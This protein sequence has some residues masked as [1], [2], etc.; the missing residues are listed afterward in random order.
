MSLRTVIQQVLLN[1]DASTEHSESEIIQLTINAAPDHDFS[2]A[3]YK[4]IKNELR[5]IEKHNRLKC[6]PNDK[7]LRLFDDDI[8]QHMICVNEDGD[9]LYK[10]LGNL[11]GAELYAQYVRKT[12]HIAHVTA[13]AEGWRIHMLSLADYCIEHG[14]VLE[15]AAKMTGRYE[16][17]EIGKETK[18]TLNKLSSTAKKETE[19]V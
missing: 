8:L 17:V 13:Q 5:D 7:Q 15:E 11:T 12:K 16:N 9:R 14:V 19:E 6:D 1:L 18:N 3:K 2:D 10:T 4:A